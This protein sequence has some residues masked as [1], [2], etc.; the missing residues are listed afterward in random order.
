MIH[1]QT[2]KL[3]ELGVRTKFLR[4]LLCNEIEKFCWL[5]DSIASR[6]VRSMCENFCL[7]YHFFLYQNSLSSTVMC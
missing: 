1:N 2:L 3:K 6:H 7:N 4:Y 5:A